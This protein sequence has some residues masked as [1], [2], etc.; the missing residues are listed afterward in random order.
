M[1]FLSADTEPTVCPKP[2]LGLLNA[3]I[4]KC[5]APTSVSATLARVSASLFG[6]MIA[7][8]LGQELDLVIEAITTCLER[9][10]LRQAYFS[11]T[12]RLAHRPRRNDHVAIT[13]P[14]HEAPTLAYLNNAAGLL[15]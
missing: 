13:R 12:R 9:R 4:S 14:F 2:A 15:N 8:C 3:S 11:S 10:A 6:V 7:P 5:F 1:L